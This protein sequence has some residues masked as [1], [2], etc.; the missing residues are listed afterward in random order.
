VK[1]QLTVADRNSSGEPNVIAQRRRRYE[2]PRLAALT[3]GEMT[4]AQIRALISKIDE[5]ILADEGGTCRAWTLADQRSVL[6]NESE[7]RR[8]WLSRNLREWWDRDV[9]DTVAISVIVVA[10][11]AIAG[12]LN[13]PW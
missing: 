3:I 6:V 13:W 5:W 12:W 11:A 8:W 10:G 1:D 4:D 9:F 7:R 2:P